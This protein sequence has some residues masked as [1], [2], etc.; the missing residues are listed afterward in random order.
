MFEAASIL[1]P[2]TLIFFAGAALGW[3]AFIAARL[4]AS[5]LQATLQPLECAEETEKLI[6]IP[7][8][9]SSGQH[10]WLRELIV[11]ACLG[12]ALTAVLAMRFGASTELALAAVLTL[13]LLILTLIDQRHLL[14]P[15]SLTLPL[16]WLG[17]LC[18]IPGYFTSLQDAVIGAVLGYGSLWSIYWLFK[19]VRGKEGLGYGDFKLTAALGAWLGWQALPGIIFTAALVGACVGLAQVIVKKRQSGQPLAFG[20]FLAAAGFVVLCTG[21][22]GPWLLSI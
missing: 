2:T 17:L 16:V 21:W 4:Y 19:L 1:G 15:D 18:N 8:N 13:V 10:Q 5:Q 7:D 22:H 6:V 11:G 12:S 3:L 9:S 20:P 14:L